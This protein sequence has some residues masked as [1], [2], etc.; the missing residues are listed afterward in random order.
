MT[1]KIGFLDNYRSSNPAESA[2]NN[3][4]CGIA[5]GEALV[6]YLKGIAPTA[7]RNLKIHFP[8]I[9]V[10]KLTGLKT[11]VA[12]KLLKTISGKLPDELQGYEI[13]I[14]GV[15]FDFIER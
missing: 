7:T 11:S 12:P 8:S 5:F 9:N 6:E 15:N 13:E 14:T 4:A 10:L 2:I 3:E 1:A